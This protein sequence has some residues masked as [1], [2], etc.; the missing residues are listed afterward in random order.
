M[1]FGSCVLSSEDSD[2]TAPEKSEA[3]HVE[4]V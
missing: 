4:I 2:A 1:L 3:T